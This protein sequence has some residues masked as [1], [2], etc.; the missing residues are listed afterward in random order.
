MRAYLDTSVILRI[1]LGQPD[2]LAQFAEIR[3]AE[4]SA[5]TWVEA[6]RTLDRHFQ[7][8]LLDPD[9]FAAA[10]ASAIDLLERV[11]RIPLS[12]TVLERAADAFP[13]PLG[14]LDA[15]HLA[16]ALAARDRLPEPLVLATH[17]RELGRASRAVGFVVLGAL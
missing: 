3:R 17:D 5:L 13:T 12:A 2:Q 4:T 9:T 1:V 6:L 8:N 11:D 10:R 7:R 16:T 15:L 14:T